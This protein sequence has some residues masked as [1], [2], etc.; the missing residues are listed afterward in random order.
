M[1]VANMAHKPDL[2]V[3]MGGQGVGKGTFSKMLMERRDYDHIEVGAI[4]RT[5]PADSEIGRTI[6]G[7]NLVPDELLFDMMRERI[8]NARDT[9][10]DGF[11]RKLTQA[12]WLVETYAT[13]H[14]VHVLYLHVPENILISRINKRI[15]EGGNRADDANPDV[16]RRR[17]ELYRTVTMPA[18]EWLRTAPHIKFSYINADGDV[19]DNFAEIITALHP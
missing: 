11:P 19:R 16:I 3:M 6:A 7:G 17:L 4:L 1:G 15:R 18:I 13:T 5:M 2:I 14:N 12:Q 8:S 10:L 9:I